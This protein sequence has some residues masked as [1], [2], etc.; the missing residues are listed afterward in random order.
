MNDNKFESI[1]TK[2]DHFQ[3]KKLEMILRHLGTNR[4]A[5]FQS[6]AEMTIRMA[7]DKHNLS[8]RMAK[9]IQMFEL[10]PGWR[11]PVSFFDPN[12]Q[13]EVV[14]AIY[15]IKQEGRA[16]LKVLK[17]ERDWMDGWMETENV[18]DIIEYLIEICL[19]NTYRWLR[20]KLVEYNCNRVFELILRIADDANAERLDKE[21][22]NMF[23]DNNRH[24]WGKEIEYGERTK[25]VKSRKVEEFITKC[26]LDFEPGEDQKEQAA[27]ASAWVE[28]AEGRDW[29]NNIDEEYDGLG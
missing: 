1:A 5:W 12:S 9:L 10:L 19:P 14:G 3:F 8:E 4:Y 15:I 27:E 11:P 26:T 17:E 6:M 24:E 29:L 28:S 22:N 18:M 7:D 20:R 13:C 23:E 16:G 25:R 21:I 2:V